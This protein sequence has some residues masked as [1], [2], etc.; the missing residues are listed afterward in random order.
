MIPS[1]QSNLSSKGLSNPRRDK[2]TIQKLVERAYWALTMNALEPVTN[3]ECY[4]Q[5]DI[6]QLT[7]DLREFLNG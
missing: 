6:E 3:S 4:N 5:S 7:D 1:I 2:E